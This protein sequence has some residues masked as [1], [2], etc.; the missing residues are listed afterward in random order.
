[1]KFRLA[2]SRETLIRNTIVEALTDA[3]RRKA[4]RD[5]LRQGRVEKKSANPT[6]AA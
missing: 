2:D 4:K 5:S 1:M 3:I 6:I